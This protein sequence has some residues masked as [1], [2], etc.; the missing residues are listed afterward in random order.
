MILIYTDYMKPTV[1]TWDQILLTLTFHT[2]G[3]F[4][5]NSGAFLNYELLAWMLD[6]LGSF[7]LN[8]RMYVA[9]DENVIRAGEYIGGQLID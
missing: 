8:R 1:S 2:V 3:L 9:L 4:I 7:R 5:D 6:A